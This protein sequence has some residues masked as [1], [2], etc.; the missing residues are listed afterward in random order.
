[1]TPTNSFTFE[2]FALN[3]SDY[4]AVVQWYVENLGLKV[5]RDTPGEKT[6]LGD[7][8]GRTVLELY[9]N[10]SAPVLDLANS[11]HLSMHVAFTVSDPDTAAEDLV[12][13]GATIIDP[14][15]TVDGDRLVMLQDPFGLSLQLIK[16]ATPM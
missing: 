12:S 7:S 14:P 13:A 10:H 15:K 8:S 9:S 16:R 2:H 3:S 5:V 6:F 11:H 1:M 4:E